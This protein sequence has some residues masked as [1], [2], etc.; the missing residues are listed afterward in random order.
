MACGF[1]AQE[2]RR[3]VGDDADGGGTSGGWRTVCVLSDPD[4]AA[5]RLQQRKK[6]IEYGKDT[7]EYAAYLR[8]VPKEQRGRDHPRTPDITESVSK[9]CFDGRVKAWRRALHGWAEAQAEAQATASAETVLAD[10]LEAEPGCPAASGARA[11]ASAGVAAVGGAAA[12]PSSFL[13]HATTRSWP[14]DGWE[15]SVDGW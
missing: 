12:A 9:R 10:E 15:R 14:L 7:P 5:Q 3:R 2:E 6:Q 1:F 4:A 8:A 13:A 11:G